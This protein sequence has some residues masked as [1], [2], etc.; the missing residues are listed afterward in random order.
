[1]VPSVSNA[2]VFN[3]C[4]V[5]HMG[6]QG[7]PLSRPVTGCGC[8]QYVLP[9]SPPASLQSSPPPILPG[10][11]PASCPSTDSNGISSAVLVLVAIVVGVVMLGFGV[12]AGQVLGRRQ[13]RRNSAGANK[14]VELS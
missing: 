9:L 4:L 14:F 12:F 13:A 8:E 3:P 1:M 7:V 5:L 11:P 2:D 6:P 10:S